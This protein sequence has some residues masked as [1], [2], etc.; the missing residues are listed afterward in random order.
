MVAAACAPGAGPPTAI[1]DA[2]EE[3]VLDLAEP[4]DASSGP[5]DVGAAE[6]TLDE[7]PAPEA[8]LPPSASVETDQLDLPEQPARSFTIVGGGDILPHMAV[9]DRAAQYGAESGEAYY[10]RPM[11]AE[12][13][14]HLQAAD[15]AVCHLEVPLSPDNAELYGGGDVR[16][17]TNQPLFLS[18]YQL[19][20]A[21]ADAGFDTCSTAHNHSL[22][23]GVEGLVG[24]LDALDR[25]GVAHAGTARTRAESAATTLLE[26]AGVTVAHL[27]STYGINDVPMPEDGAWMVDVTD[28]DAIL[29]EADRAR[30]AGA[31]FVVLSLHQGRE[32]HVEP[33]E[34]Q[35]DNAEVL[36]ADGG[37]DLIIGHHAHVVQP[38][39]RVHDRVTAHGVGNLL[40]NMHAEFTGPNSQDGILAHF[41]VT[42]TEPGSFEVTD[43]GYVP[44]WVDRSRHLVVDVG[45]AL[46][47]DRHPQ[48]RAELTA[49]WERTLDAV[50]RDGASAWGVAPLTGPADDGRR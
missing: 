6:F 13:A 44:L 3:T 7:A 1:G 23:G 25:V 37:V 14:P 28:H 4:P 11:F 2:D 34:A 42:E 41:E 49:S 19:A 50:D 46:A 47:E 16:T 18:P 39:E 35:R 17:A 20:D 8:D 31:E 38:I 27:S 30:D 45:T 29:A 48:L 43:V 9:I 24:T 26:V 36:L 21:I 12:I 5:G 32:Y 22:D 10:F 40:S 15:L 33:S